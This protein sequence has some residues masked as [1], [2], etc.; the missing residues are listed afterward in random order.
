MA[1]QVKAAEEARIEAEA[2]AKQ[3]RKRKSYKP[4]QR[5]RQNKARLLPPPAGK[6]FKPAAKA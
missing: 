3:K 5:R 6:L 1:V 4:K 2:K